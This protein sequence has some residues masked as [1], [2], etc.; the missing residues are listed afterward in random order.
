MS[1]THDTKTKIIITNITFEKAYNSY[2]SFY[3]YYSAECLSKREGFESAFDYS[4][5]DNEGYVV[6]SDSVFAP[7]MN[8]GE[9]TKNQSFKIDLQHVNGADLKKGATYKLKITDID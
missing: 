1:R 8:T 2:S 9:K 5:C 7:D 6:T 4:L 3:V